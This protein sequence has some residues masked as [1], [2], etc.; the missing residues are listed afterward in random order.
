MHIDVTEERVKSK[1]NIM[2]GAFERQAVEV[3]TRRIPYA[4]IFYL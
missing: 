4:C 1:T 3:R 2:L